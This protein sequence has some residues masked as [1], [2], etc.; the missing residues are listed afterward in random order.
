ML[1]EVMPD[2]AYTQLVFTIPKI[3]RKAFLYRRELYGELCKVAYA[4]TRDFFAAPA[5]VA[6]RN[7]RP[8]LDRP[9]PAITVVPQSFGDL[10]L[11]HALC[12]A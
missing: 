9:M 7:H 10:L 1:A 5:C 11:P 6:E 12:Y 8:R 3:L 2:T 4:S